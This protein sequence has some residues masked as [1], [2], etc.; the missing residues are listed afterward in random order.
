M[1]EIQKTIE[2]LD[3]LISFPTVSS[4]SNRDCIDWI[5]DYLKSYGATCKISSEADGK[6]NIFATLG[7]DIDG[8]IILSGHTDVVPVIGQNWSS[9]PFKM[10]RENDSFYGRG[11]CDMKGFIASTLA[12]VPKNE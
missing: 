7:P 8:G 2:I 12:M 5:S 1:T 10:K 11:T 6:A 4:E 3:K 9:D